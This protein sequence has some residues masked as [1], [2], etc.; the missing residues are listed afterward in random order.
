MKEYVKCPLMRN[1]CDNAC[2][3][4]DK[5]SQNY[6]CLIASSLRRMANALENIDECL[7][8]GGHIGSVATA[9]DQALMKIPGGERKG[10]GQEAGA[11]DGD[12]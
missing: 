4:Y 12:D 1:E 8:D 6:T 10:A 9:I 2:A 3:M 7:C 5:F 11:A